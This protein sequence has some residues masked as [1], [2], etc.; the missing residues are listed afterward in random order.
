MVAHTHKQEANMA[1]IVREEQ[2]ENYGKVLYIANGKQEMR[3]TLD[4]GPRVI[5][6]NLIGYKNMFCNDLSRVSNMTDKEFLDI[7][8]KDKVWYLYGGHRFWISPEDYS[9]Y[10]PDNDPVTYKQQGNVFTFTP[11]IQEVRGWLCEVEITFDEVE[12]KASVRHILTNK[13]EE[14]KKGSIWALSVTAE[15]G[16]AIM[17]QSKVETGFL[18]NRTFVMWDYTNPA[19]DRFHVDKDYYALQQKNVPTPF[20]I[21]VN[22]VKGSVITIN[23]GCI[24][25]KTYSHIQ[26]AEYPDGGCSTELY[27]CN[28]MLEV[29][30]LSPLY[31]LKPEESAE[32]TEN[33]ELIPEKSTN[34]NDV[35]KYL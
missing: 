6:Y 18:P 23:N 24:F 22:N 13:S 25:K 31:T 30:S 26:N 20:K 12:A 33:W 35:V 17:E 28:F 15:G 10:Y 32:H 7:Y 29:E 19:D 21:G 27:T 3:V 9:T 16:R 11:P 2:Y 5:S 14:T 1:L 4:L 8:G 34:L